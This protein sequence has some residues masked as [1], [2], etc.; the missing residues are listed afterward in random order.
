MQWLAE[1]RKHLEQQDDQRYKT[2][3]LNF[4][5]QATAAW[6][7]RKDSIID[8]LKRQNARR[9]RQVQG[10]KRVSEEINQKR[11]QDPPDY[12]EKKDILG[13]LKKKGNE[14]IDLTDRESGEMRFAVGEKQGT[15]HRP[16]KPDPPGEDGKDLERQV[17]QMSSI[18]PEE[19]QDEDGKT[20]EAETIDSSF[21]ETREGNEENHSK[22]L[23]S[24][25]KT[26]EYL[27]ET[28]NRYRQTLE[29]SKF[30]TPKNCELQQSGVHQLSWT[31]PNMYPNDK[32]EEEI[33]FD[34]QDDEE[35]IIFST[36]S[37]DSGDNDDEERLVEAMG[38]PVVD[39]NACFSDRNDQ[40]RR[41]KCSHTFVAM[42]R[43]Y[44]C[45]WIRGTGVSRFVCSDALMASQLLLQGAD[46]STRRSCKAAN[47]AL[48]GYSPLCSEQSGETDLKDMVRKFRV[49][50]E[51]SQLKNVWP[52]EGS[53][54]ANTNEYIQVSLQ[55]YH[56]HLRHV[57]NVLM[58]CIGEALS[59]EDIVVEISSTAKGPEDSLL[60][61][62]SCGRGSRHVA[63]KPIVAPFTERNFLSILLQDAGDCAV[64]QHKAPDGSW[65]TVSIPAP[66]PDDAVFL[67]Y[68]GE[69]LQQT[70]RNLFPVIQRRMVPGNGHES[71]NALIFSSLSLLRPTPKFHFQTHYDSHR[72]DISRYWDDDDGSAAEEG[73]QRASLDKLASELRE[74]EIAFGENLKLGNDDIDDVLKLATKLMQDKN[75]NNNG[76]RQTSRNETKTA[77]TPAANESLMI[78]R[79]C[80]SPSEGSQGLELPMPEESKRAT[81]PFLNLKTERL[82]KT[83]PFRLARENLLS[84]YTNGHENAGISN[85]RGNELPYRDSTSQR[86]SKE[87]SRL[88]PPNFDCRYPLGVA[89]PKRQEHQLATK[90]MDL[91]MSPYSAIP[92]SVEKKR[93]TDM[94]RRL[95]H[96]G[97]PGRP[98]LIEDDELNESSQSRFSAPRPIDSHSFSMIRQTPASNMNPFF[99]FSGEPGR[100][101]FS[102]TSTPV[103]SPRESTRGTP[104]AANRSGGYA[105]ENFAADHVS[106]PT[107]GLY[108]NLRRSD[109]PNVTGAGVSSQQEI[110]RERRQHFLELKSPV[111]VEKSATSEFRRDANEESFLGQSSRLGASQ[112]VHSG[113]ENSERTPTVS[114]HD[115]VAQSVCSSMVETLEASDVLEELLSADDKSGRVAGGHQLFQNKEAR[116]TWETNI[117]SNT[118]D[119]SSEDDK[120]PSLEDFS[121]TKIKLQ[122]SG[123]LTLQNSETVVSKKPS[124]SYLFNQ[125]ITFPQPS[126]HQTVNDPV[127]GFSAN[128]PGTGRP[129]PTRK[130]MKT[131]IT[132]NHMQTPMVNSGPNQATEESKTNVMTKEDV[133]N[134]GR[135]RQWKAE[136]ESLKSHKGS[137]QQK[138]KSD[139]TTTAVGVVGGSVSS[140]SE[141]TDE[142]YKFGCT[143]PLTWLS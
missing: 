26:S 45:A 87:L 83:N 137:I 122:P 116:S 82:K 60:S 103:T 61:A 115:P 27:S 1:R 8:N 62:W 58:E 50:P 29:G 19:I 94:V 120:I 66:T 69:F 113:I 128:T 142:G 117:L 34:S 90:E 47:S 17:Q 25:A 2:K 68:A 41:R 98:I 36:A 4:K 108:R 18:D 64:F 42:L 102:S 39:M 97:S 44:G 59:D 96:P 110:V 100:N 9:R 5:K 33:V 99:I 127:D 72:N 135:Y 67:V 28:I 70:T 55:N 63:D 129:S 88:L 114:L 143:V 95:D 112:D 125:T 13:T 106:I 74:A 93:Q 76:K 141:L 105:F 109:P 121:T 32:E 126:E 52:R 23:D 15:K 38:D 118:V 54:D 123:H 30:E 56:D 35:E 20:D 46:E 16:E 10:E 92:K 104:I 111:R 65:E 79:R 86:R 53:L 3:P 14:I 43:Q 132:V 140:V 85:T 73:W 40:G 11:A 57:G 138:V 80:R 101:I 77:R 22:S 48:R 24:L 131:K 51:S 21:I 71:T 31:L 107:L 133:V 130:N 49:G 6:Q 7:K 119:S 78:A 91:E 89:A 124:N 84:K 139:K 75:G 81:L 134:M 37:E 12:E 136:R